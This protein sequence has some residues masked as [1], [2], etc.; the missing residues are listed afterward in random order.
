MTNAELLGTL[1]S[2][3][4]DESSY[5]ALILLPVVQVAWA[6]GAVTAKEHKRILQA[7][8]DEF[9]LKPE[10]RQALNGWLAY[11]PSDP[12]FT[13]G[14]KGLAVLALRIRGM[15]LMDDDINRWKTLSREVAKAD[16]GILGMFSV[17]ADEKAAI[18]RMEEALAEYWAPV[19]ASLADTLSD[20]LASQL[21][22]ANAGVHARLAYTNT[23]DKLVHHTID[24]HGLTIGRHGDNDLA[25]RIDAYV[26]RRHCRIF[27]KYGKFWLEDA[28]S[29]HGTL[30]NGE[31]VNER[32]L[33]DGDIITVGGV[34]MTF[35]LL[36]PEQTE[37]A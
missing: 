5:R 16:G 23:E 17:R 20:V 10:A 36:A 7:V 8:D 12:F 31:H 11:R 27:E 30:V 26:S 37:A 14:I 18:V 15:S 4:L 6:D 29:K 19:D 1:N 33:F 3:G 25:I 21:L 9:K 35:E 13:T 32:R 22:Q 24:T 34:D 28:D 2:L